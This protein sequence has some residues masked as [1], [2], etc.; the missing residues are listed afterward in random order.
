MASKSL[1]RTC[2]QFVVVGFIA[3]NADY[4]LEGAAP[5]LPDAEQVPVH[6]YIDKAVKFLLSRQ[7]SDGSFIELPPDGDQPNLRVGVSAVCGM[8]LLRSVG[9]NESDDRD[10]ALRRVVGFLRSRTMSDGLICDSP[11]E[12]ETAGHSYATWF[13]AEAALHS[14]GKLISTAEVETAAIKLLSMQHHDGGWGRFADPNTPSDLSNTV[15]ALSALRACTNNGI[16]VAPEVW[17]ASDRFLTRCQIE[18]G[19]FSVLAVRRQDGGVAAAAHGAVGLSLT[20]CDCD[21]R[22]ERCFR[23]LNIHGAHPPDGVEDSFQLYGDFFLSHAIHRASE[24]QRI[25]W[26]KATS[27]NLL[28]LQDEFGSWDDPA[29]PEFGTALALLVLTKF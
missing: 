9:P 23:Y 18:S 11:H 22:L 12:N 27:S 10:D 17:K 20:G 16:Q 6:R 4:G 28:H 29:G 2:L 25:S 15:C 7:K 14:S 24:S 1:T 26:Q 5:I 13:L 19:G 8:A 3:L 21:D